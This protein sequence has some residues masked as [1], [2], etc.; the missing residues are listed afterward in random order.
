MAFSANFICFFQEPLNTRT[1][2]SCGFF[3]KTLCNQNYAFQNN[4]ELLKEGL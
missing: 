4:Q 3:E 1:V 2:D